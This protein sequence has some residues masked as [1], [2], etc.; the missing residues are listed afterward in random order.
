MAREINGI[1]YRIRGYSGVPHYV[2]CENL[3]DL[4]CYIAENW[5]MKNYPI[6]SVNRMN[7]DGT[8]PKVALRANEDFKRILSKYQNFSYAAKRLMDFNYYVEFIGTN[9]A[10]V[11]FKD[12]SGD[13]TELSPCDETKRGYVTIEGKVQNIDKWL[14]G[15]VV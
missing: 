5:V 10:R 1:V 13:F 14:F 11:Y 3:Y 8:T 4:Y 6:S 2:E 12:N 7:A 9:C 15:R